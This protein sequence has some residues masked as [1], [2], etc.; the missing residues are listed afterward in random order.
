MSADIDGTDRILRRIHQR[1]A[2]RRAAPRRGARRTVLATIRE[3]PHYLRL[4]AGLLTDSRVSTLDK[5][6]VGGALAYIIMPVDLIPDV[7]PFFGQVDDIYLL[8]VAL[9]RLIFHAGTRVLADH[10]GGDPDA[11]TPGHLRQVL[12][13]TS[14]F[15]PRRLRRRL[16]ALV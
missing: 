6:L 10:W 13:A 16:R 12:F 15:L 8:V 3:I 4:L 7:I 2:S 11:L 5:L 1:T 9:Q 14:F